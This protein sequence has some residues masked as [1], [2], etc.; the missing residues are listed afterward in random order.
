MDRGIVTNWDDMEEVWHD[1]FYN[2]LRADPNEHSVLI[3]EPPFN[4]KR[5]RE[6]TAEVRLFILKRPL[7]NYL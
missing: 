5:N 6:K 2:E 3:T 7:T 1:T 4:P